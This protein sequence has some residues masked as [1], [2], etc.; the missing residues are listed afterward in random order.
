MAY[1]IT[2]EPSGACFTAEAGQTVLEAALA[3]GVALQHGCG[4][5]SCGDCKGTVLEGQ[6][7]QGIYMPLLLTPEE[8][9]AGAAI[10]C[11]FKPTSDL[12]VAATVAATERF[13]AEIRRLR[14]LG[15]DVM[16]LWLQ[17]DAPLPY[18]PGQYVRVEV[19]GHPGVMRSYSIA[20]RPNGDGT[21]EFHIRRAPGGLFSTQLFEH[22][23]P[24]DR[25]RLSA[26]QGSFRLHADSPRDLLCIAAGTGLAP[27]K[28]VLEEAFDQGIDRRIHLFFGAKRRQDLY[29]LDLLADWA[30]RYPNFR[31]T[32]TIS[33]PD[34][35]DWTGAR[36]LLPTVAQH[37]AWQDH[38]TYLCGSPGMINAAIELLRSHGT[39]PEHIHFDAFTPN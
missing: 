9:A 24:G 39:P 22:L 37:G 26:A 38:E 31:F 34:E 15:P 5:G 29:H 8:K 11:K 27:I 14:R 25:L 10:L 30:A 3:H 32:P 23:R 7:E 35:V 2:V 4:N 28:A 16:G 33:D 19:P 20:N 1:R 18:Q 12:C 6:G 13:D 17:P 36:R 21:L